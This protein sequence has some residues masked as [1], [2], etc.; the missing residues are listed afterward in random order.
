MEELFLGIL[1]ENLPDTGYYRHFMLEEGGIFSPSPKQEEQEQAAAL[2]LRLSRPVPK[3]LLP[4]EDFLLFTFKQHL[5]TPSLPLSWGL[6][7]P[8]VYSACLPPLPP[9]M[10][11]AACLHCNTSHL[12]HT[13]T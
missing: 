6:D 13:P 3:H 11:V 8:C 1:Q 9:K 10:T 2:L 4:G 7:L 12:L 5:L